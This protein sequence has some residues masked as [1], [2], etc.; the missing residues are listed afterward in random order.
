MSFKL[1]NISD[2]T[3]NNINDLVEKSANGDLSLNASGNVFL[4]PAESKNVEIKTSGIDSK[5]NIL[6]TDGVGGGGGG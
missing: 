3:N 5:V 6:L 2:L 1:F 4:V